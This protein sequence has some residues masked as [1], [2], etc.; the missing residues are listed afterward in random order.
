MP[1]QSSPHPSLSLSSSPASADGLDLLDPAVLLKTHG[2]PRDA[3]PRCF[4]SSVPTPSRVHPLTCVLSVASRPPRSPLLS[5]P[6]NCTVGPRVSPSLRGLSSLPFALPQCLSPQLI[7]LLF[8]TVRL[9][10]LSHPLFFLTPPT[11]NPSPPSSPL[12]PPVSQPPIPSS[13]KPKPAR[14]GN[15]YPRG[16]VR[17]AP[18]VPH[19]PHQDDPAPDSQRKCKSLSPSLSLP[20]LVTSRQPSQ[21]PSCSSWFSPSWWP[22]SL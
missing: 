2:P 16:G 19:Q 8:S 22:P 1:A 6:R 14:S 10:L 7:P 9:F 3:L 17:S 18:K 20:S 15:Y 21:I 11:D 4:P 13:N 5:P 12:P